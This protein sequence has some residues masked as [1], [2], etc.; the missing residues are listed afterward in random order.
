MELVRVLVQ[1]NRVNHEVIWQNNVHCAV[2][3]SES[4]QLRRN[5]YRSPHAA[6]TPCRILGNFIYEINIQILPHRYTE[7]QSKY[8]YS[9][10][11]MNF[12]LASLQ[13]LW[14]EI[15][16]C[17]VNEKLSL[18]RIFGLPV[19]ICGLDQVQPETYTKLQTLMDIDKFVNHVS[20]P[21]SDI[22]N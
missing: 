19:V 12:K 11:G 20:T 7:E 6:I 13:L 3:R 2:A 1:Q 5:R 15:Q 8:S 22:H 4:F 9:I 10:A 18:G 16:Q 21:R 14:T 17:F